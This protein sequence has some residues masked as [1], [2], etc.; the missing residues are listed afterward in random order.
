MGFEDMKPHE[1]Q[2]PKSYEEFKRPIIITKDYYDK[3]SVQEKIKYENR[4]KEKMKDLIK[5]Y[6]VGYIVS[7]ILIIL[8]I[9]SGV[10]FQG[11]MDMTFY[12]F[13]FST[14]IV[15]LFLI[16]MFIISDYIWYFLGYRKTS[17]FYQ[18]IFMKRKL[19]EAKGSKTICHD[20]PY[21]IIDDNCYLNGISVV[22]NSTKPYIIVVG[23]RGIGKS[24]YSKVMSAYNKGVQYYSAQ[25]L[26]QLDYIIRKR[27]IKVIA[28]QNVTDGG[29]NK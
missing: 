1:I 20:L 5:Y 18:Y 10:L 27:A 13:V 12:D 11:T 8:F 26:V 9:L 2:L 15:S 16:F 4:R 3:L 19:K 29:S 7:L 22:F 28:I 17:T 14:L 23:D 25:R 24:V 6:L 21:G